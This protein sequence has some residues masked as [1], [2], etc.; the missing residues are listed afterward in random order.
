MGITLK[1]PF[2]DDKGVLTYEVSV[3][4]GKC[5]NCISRRRMEWGFR[6]EKEMERSKTC[7][8]ATLTYDNEHVPYDKY[9]NMILVK[10]DVINFMK[11]L[12]QNH[13][14]NNIERWEHYYNGLRNDDKIKFY[15]AGEY[16]EGKLT[17]NGERPHYHLILFNASESIIKETWEKGASFIVP[18]NG[19][20]IGYVTKYLDKWKN[21][22]ARLEKAERI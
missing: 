18:G 15:C 1:E 14:R 6:M 19:A 5:E 8:F 20:T 2:Y 13:V 17:G 21:K 12:R 16:G 9:G 7:L 22:K 11:R 10:R 3:P 4:C